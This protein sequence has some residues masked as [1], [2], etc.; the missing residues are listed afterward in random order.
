MYENFDK[1]KE[2]LDN[3]KSKFLENGPRFVGRIEVL[4]ES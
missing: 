3:L 1:V 2:V 4:L